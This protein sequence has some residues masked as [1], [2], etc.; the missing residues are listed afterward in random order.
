MIK[1]GLGVIAGIVAVFLF[2]MFFGGSYQLEGS[3]LKNPNTIMYDNFVVSSDLIFV[4]SKQIDDNAIVQ[5][6]LLQAI[7]RRTLKEVW[8]YPTNG[9]KKD[10]QIVNDRIFLLRKFVHVLDA[11]TGTKI[12]QFE[13]KDGHVQSIVADKDQIFWQSDEGVYAFDLSSRNVAWMIPVVNY[14]S[15]PELRFSGNDLV[16]FGGDGFIHIVDKFTGKNKSK[17]SFPIM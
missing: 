17:T 12:L 4:L 10:I 1:F 9:V 15:S 11:K 13:I 16:F 8:R 14:I 2:L 6:S 3:L 7:D 5:S